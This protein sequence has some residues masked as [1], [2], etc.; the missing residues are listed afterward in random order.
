MKCEM[1]E[2]IHPFVN[3]IDARE[4]PFQNLSIKILLKNDA[5]KLR[6]MRF[7]KQFCERNLGVK[8]RS[9][10]PNQTLSNKLK[11]HNKTLSNSVKHCVKTAKK[12]KKHSK[13]LK[14]RGKNEQKH[15]DHMIDSH[16]HHVTPQISRVFPK[17]GR[18]WKK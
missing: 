2:E 3:L 8:T 1:N 17:R 16:S 18:N 9:R 15:D 13:K 5:Q 12:L 6:K 10:D 14:K 7:L 11:Q 4:M